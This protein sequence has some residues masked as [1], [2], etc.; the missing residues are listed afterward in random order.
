MR[1]LGPQPEDRLA[2]ESQSL[3]PACNITAVGSLCPLA[4][5]WGA[6]TSQQAAGM[7]ASDAAQACQAAGTAEFACRSCCCECA[8]SS[9][10]HN[11]SASL[12]SC[13]E[14]QAVL[15]LQCNTMASSLYHFDSAHSWVISYQAA[16]CCLATPPWA[17]AEGQTLLAHSEFWHSERP[18]DCCATIRPG[19]SRHPAHLQH[20]PTSISWPTSGVLSGDTALGTIKSAADLS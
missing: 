20:M 18:G 9:I 1:A 17:Q 3:Q 19:C 11:I 5:R 15:C 4:E 14:L 2:S 13:R 7:L 10:K 6:L 8:R 16:A 12:A